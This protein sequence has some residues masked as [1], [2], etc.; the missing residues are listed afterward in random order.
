MSLNN[1]VLINV[2]V[3]PA[4]AGGNEPKGGHKPTGKGDY[5]V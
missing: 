5:Y 4:K 1:E 2:R 3:T